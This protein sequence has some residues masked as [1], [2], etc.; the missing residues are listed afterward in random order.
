MIKP[1]KLVFV[2]FPSFCCLE[3]KKPSCSI[4][5]GDLEDSVCKKPGPWKMFIQAKIGAAICCLPF[6]A[7]Y[8]LPAWKFKI[9]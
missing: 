6:W 2:M 3:G 4:S 9:D 8:H 7:E 5:Q 1:L